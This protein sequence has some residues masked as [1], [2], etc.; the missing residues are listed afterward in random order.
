MRLL[1]E[2][3]AIAMSNGLK[4]HLRL[5]QVQGMQTIQTFVKLHG[6]EYLRQFLQ[7][8]DTLHIK[9]VT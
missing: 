1:L 2:G 5:Y 9:I 8:R 4:N 7:V 3:L 6:E